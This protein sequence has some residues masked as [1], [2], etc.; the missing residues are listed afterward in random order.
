[1]SGRSL[2][3]GKRVYYW[4]KC[5]RCGRFSGPGPRHTLTAY[6]EKTGEEYYYCD[7]SHYEAMEFPWYETTKRL[8]EE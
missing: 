1:M 7:L 2:R 8:H 5:P 6:G 3:R 4:T